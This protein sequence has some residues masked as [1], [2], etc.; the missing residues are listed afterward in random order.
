MTTLIV[1]RKHLFF[2]E[3]DEILRRRLI[4]ARPEHPRAYKGGAGKGVSPVTWAIINIP[5]EGL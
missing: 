5:R 1:A 2:V 3:L 4:A